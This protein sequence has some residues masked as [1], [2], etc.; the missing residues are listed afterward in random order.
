M[1]AAHADRALIE[2]VATG[3]EP[4]SRGSGDIGPTSRGLGTWVLDSWGWATHNARV[5]HVVLFLMTQTTPAPPTEKAR[6]IVMDLKRT[7]VG[8]SVARVLT[9]TLSTELG[10]GPFA[11]VTSADLRAVS[12]VDAEK[13]SAGVCTDAVACEAEMADA[14]GADVLV[15]GSV[16]RF[17]DNMIVTVVMYD[18]KR[19]LAIGREKVQDDDIDRLS[20]KVEIAAARL[21]AL[22][23]GEEP[24]EQLPDEAPRSA[25][26]V[27]VLVTGGVVAVVGGVIAG[28]GAYGA[29]SSLGVLQLP[30]SS[31]A[32][33]TVARDS[34]PLQTGLLVG[35]SALAVA[36]VVVAAASLA[37]E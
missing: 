15:H 16:V 23:L 11:V 24:P 37:I 31:G 27:P 3:G 19:N 17:D 13:Q 34:Y 35:G 18:R 32:Q 4:A 30:G 20:E 5:L 8:S 14:L 26:F 1:V 6:L 29:S 28:V 22:Y 7:R 10:R 33:K 9:D 12:N 21:T 36:G 2:N 25:L